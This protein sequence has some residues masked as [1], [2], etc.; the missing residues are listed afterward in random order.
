MS[1]LG[2]L[3]A[4]HELLLVFVVMVTGVLLGRVSFFGTRLGVAGVLF[5]GIA[6]AVIARSPDHALAITPILR[7]FGLVL[8]V[9]S[10]GISSGPG[11]FRA[12]REQ[13]VRFNLAVLSALAA[14]GGLAALAGW[15]FDLDRGFVT[16]IFCGALTNTPALGAAAERLAGTELAANPAMGYAVAYPFGVFGALLMLR[17]FARLRDKRLAAEQTAASPTELRALVT[18]NFRVTRAELDQKAIGA[19]RV[20]DAVGVMISRLGRGGDARVPTKY[21]ALALGDIV[22]VVGSADAIAKAEAYFGE[23]ATEHLELERGRIDMRRML[24][25]RREFVGKRIGDLAIG[26][27]FGAQIT[28][29]RRADVDL[30]PS[31]DMRLELGDRIRVVAP[32][33]RLAEVSRYFG[34]SERDLAQVDFAALAI[35]LCLGLLLALVPMPG[36]GGLMHLGVAGGTLVA[37]L[38]L[39]RLGR[40]GPLVWSIPYE[41]NTMMRDFGLLLFLAGVGVTAGGAFSTLDPGSALTMVA[42]G[43][44]ITVATSAIGLLLLHRWAGASVI[45]SMGATAGLQTQPATLASAYDMSGRS[46]ETYVAYALVF[47]VAMIGKIL[48]AQLLVMLLG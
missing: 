31:P 2:E 17:L 35:G 43:G 21:D 15:L 41:A 4:E 14:A 30:L 45:S 9:Y 23:R 24:V 7:D 10:V 44:V 13:G 47:P 46:E 40:T 5:A 39:G 11:F 26:P 29:L 28:R 34:D 16:G 22:T 8:F 19:L 20:R 25:S 27:R 33:E 36:P 48:L 18:A 38:V 6:V 42:V 1:A 12:W 32:A 3:L 37:A